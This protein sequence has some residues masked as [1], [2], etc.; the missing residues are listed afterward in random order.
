MHTLEMVV[1]RTLEN[2]LI[3]F[4]VGKVDKRLYLEANRNAGRAFALHWNIS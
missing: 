2:Q 4:T 3:F 1:K